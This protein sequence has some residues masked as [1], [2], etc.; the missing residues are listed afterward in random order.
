MNGIQM[1]VSDCESGM[2]LYAVCLDQLSSVL[3][4]EQSQ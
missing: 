1:Q 4:E 2:D 3:D